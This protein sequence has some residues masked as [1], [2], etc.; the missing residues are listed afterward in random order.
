[1][2]KRERSEYAKE[3]SELGAAKGGRARANALTEE[4]RREIARQAAIK[5]WEKAG[6]RKEKTVDEQQDQTSNPVPEPNPAVGPVEPQGAMP[7]SMFRG[8]L[9]F[10][11]MDIECHVLNDGRRVFTQGEVVRVLTR[12]TES[13]NL[14]RYLSRN[15]LIGNDFSVGPIPF[16]I[17]GNPTT[18]IGSEATLLVEIC[19]RYLDARAQGLLKRSQLAL[20]AQA[21]IVVRTCAKVG[22]IALIDEATGYQQVRARNALQLKLQAFIAEEMQEWAVMFPSEFWMEMARLEGIHYSPRNRPLRWGKY[23][24]MFVYDAIDADV[25]NWLRENNPNP[26]FLRNHHQWLKKFGREKVH[27]QIMQVIAVMK[28]CRD[29]ADFKTKFAHVFKKSPL[30]LTFDDINWTA[31][32]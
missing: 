11:D 7:F 14:T 25:G 18:A 29:V 16:K 4:E 3:L 19:E 32:G 15:P 8:T 5:R 12:G 21:E 30:Q 2:N 24:M 28:L 22:V 10:G 20:A 17:P 9:K 27:D 1:M 6:K 13:S 31:P 26:H 23:V